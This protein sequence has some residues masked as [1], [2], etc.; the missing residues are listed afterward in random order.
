[1]NLART[2][3]ELFGSDE[4]DSDHDKPTW[5]TVVRSGRAVTEE[6]R[7]AVNI[8]EKQIREDNERRD[9]LKRDLEEQKRLEEAEAEKER[10]SLE[11]ERNSMI[12]KV[13]IEA[14]EVVEPD[15]VSDFDDT[16]TNTELLEATGG[17]NDAVTNEELL[18]AAQKPMV[19]DMDIEAVHVAE[20]DNNSRRVV[21]Q[22][23]A[24]NRN[25]SQ[26]PNLPSLNLEKTINLTL[27]V[28]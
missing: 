14:K 4:D 27:P 24:W 2:F 18:K 16:V 19:Q 28:N 15:A 26:G 9:K 22:F 5:A 3:D 21:E 1:M 10:I 20:A 6:H 8:Y 7:S 17:L 25:R 13:A 23:L 11:Q 12:E